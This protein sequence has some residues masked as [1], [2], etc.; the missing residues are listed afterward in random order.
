MMLKSIPFNKLPWYQPPRWVVHHHHHH[1]HYHYHNVGNSSANPQLPVPNP[2]L[3]VPFVPPLA[4]P[5]TLAAPTGTTPAPL[6]LAAPTRTTPAPLLQR[7]PSLSDQI[8][9]VPT[10]NSV[11]EV[12]N[13]YSSKNSS[14]QKSISLKAGSNSKNDLLKRIIESG[15]LQQP[16]Q[17][18]QPQKSEL[19]AGSN[20]KNDLLK[21]IIESG[22]LQQLQQPP[23]QPQKSEKQPRRQFF[24]RSNTSLDVTTSRL[25]SGS[26][27][28]SPRSP[29]LLKSQNQKENQTP[30]KHQNSDPSSTGS[31]TP[32][33]STPQ[34][35]IVPLKAKEL[36][37]VA[38]LL[39]RKMSSRS[40]SNRAAQPSNEGQQ[41]VIFTFCLGASL[42]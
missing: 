42:L 28:G 4:P 31:S 29:R 22:Q 27:P 15:Q 23:Q 33:G 39:A 13:G 24:G 18:Q 37:T 17:P 34:P 26:K 25:G 20:S 36:Q 40:R 41:I 9:P 10:T 30:I 32:T 3:P 19:K 21:K 35:P 5:L 11:K 7:P 38:T 6:T 12:T 14:P 2:Q 8:D 1:H 16:Q